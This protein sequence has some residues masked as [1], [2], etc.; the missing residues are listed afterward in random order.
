MLYETHSGCST[1]L[2]F[3][4]IRTSKTAV[5]FP[6]GIGN[7]EP[8]SETTKRWVLLLNV[9]FLYKWGLCETVVEFAKKSRKGKVVFFGPWNHQREREPKKLPLKK[10]KTAFLKTNKDLLLEKFPLFSVYINDQNS[11]PTGESHSLQNRH[12]FDWRERDT[13]GRVTGCFQLE[14]LVYDF[15]M[16]NLNHS[17]YL[18]VYKLWT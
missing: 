17:K 9:L 18:M 2:V 10:L 4:T 12:G 13:A 7:P 1:H 15:Q 14:I 3:F 16:R 6:I 8:K 11:R 5:I